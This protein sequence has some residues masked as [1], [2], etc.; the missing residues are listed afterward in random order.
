M[1]YSIMKKILTLLFLL[2]LISCKKEKFDT[3]IRQANVFDGT[4]KSSVKLDVGIRADTIAAVG[5]L[6]KAEADQ[7]IEGNDLALAPGFIDTHSHH[8]WGLNKNPD[9]L[10]VV[11]QGVTTIIVGQDGGSSIPLKDYFKT[12]QDSAVAVNIGSYSGH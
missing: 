1:K 8:G 11:S 3:I 12:L 6:S 9:A 4:G 7:I 2:T 5:D 10:A